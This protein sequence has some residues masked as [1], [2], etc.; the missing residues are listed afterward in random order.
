MSFLKTISLFF[1][2]FIFSQATFAFD[3]T[4]Q[5]NPKTESS[6]TTV[7][8]SYHEK[9][10][11]YS[12]IAKSCNFEKDFINYWER[13]DKSLV[14][15]GDEALDAVSQITTKTKAHILEG[16]VGWGYVKGDK[17]WTAKGVHHN[18]AIA[19]GFAK[20]DETTLVE[21]PN[22]IYKAKVFVKEGDKWT[23]KLTNN[24]YSTFF[25]ISWGENKVF[26]EISNAYKNKELVTGNTWRGFSTDGK[27]EI[28]MYLDKDSNITSA[29]PKDF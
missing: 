5:L 25:P 29:F 26:N 22:G 20:V 18:S 27:T 6:I 13:D 2:Y 7:N 24:G 19:K 4:L 15:T 14:K 28:W 21:G 9:H 11:I 23:P 12:E 1:I 8:L 16:E 10:L 3:I 17:V